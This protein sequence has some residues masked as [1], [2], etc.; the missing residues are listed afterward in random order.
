MK[1]VGFGTSLRP[2]TLY[3]LEKG[4]NRILIHQ[5]QPQPY[6]RVIWVD[7]YIGHKFE[8]VDTETKQSFGIYEVA[9]DSFYMIGQFYS[10][11]NPDI[12]MSFRRKF[13]EVYRHWRLRSVVKRTF[14]ELG[15]QHG[16]LPPDL[17]NYL[18]TYYYNNQY[19][20]LREDGNDQSLTTN[21]WQADTH[22][23]VM[24]FRIKVSKIAWILITYY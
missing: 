5:F 22:L 2:F 19:Q 17:F 13:Y 6:K 3:F 12:S 20:Y 11:V 21:F 1:E 14:T 8:V 10:G 16:H 23:I 24:P 4:I 15:F 18:S 9:H 7:S